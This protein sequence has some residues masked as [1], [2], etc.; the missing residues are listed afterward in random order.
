MNNQTIMCCVVALILGMLLFHMLKG[1]CGCKVVEGQCGAVPSH[2][3]N[4]DII[5]EI[6]NTL[7]TGDECK[8]CLN[9]AN[10]NLSATELGDY[11]GSNCTSDING[12]C[13][14]VGSVDQV[15]TVRN[16]A[17]GGC[18]TCLDI[19]YGGG[20]DTNE[21]L[22][23]YWAG[24]CTAAKVGEELYDQQRIQTPIFVDSVYNESEDSARVRFTVA[25]NCCDINDTGAWE[26]GGIWFNTPC[27]SLES[28]EQEGTVLNS[29][30][31][32]DVHFNDITVNND[33]R[34]FCNHQRTVYLTRPN[35]YN[36]PQV[37]SD[38][39]ITA[40]NL[41]ENLPPI[42][43]EPVAPAP[44]ALAPVAPVSVAP[45]PVAPA[46]AYGAAMPC[47]EQDSCNEYCPLANSEQIRQW[48]DCTSNLINQ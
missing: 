5:T 14:P 41:L 24:N 7:K 39:T 9:G 32:S 25:K 30:I 26:S 11:W 45:S 47:S 16:K 46:P 2:D 31:Q 44:V 33:V 35:Q 34:D 13:G 21:H 17:R 48:Y 6:Y 20:M 12:G 19:G 29:I 1:V 40:E 36:T 4:P 15:G 27:G 28:P 37:V 22:Y 43:L 8:R 10:E 18:R 38:Q 42:N 23:N 3:Q